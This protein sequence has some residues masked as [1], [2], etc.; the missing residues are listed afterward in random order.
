MGPNTPTISIENLKKSLVEVFP[1]PVVSDHFYI[2]SSNEIELVNILSIKGEL[3]H[4]FKIPVAQKS[5]T[6]ENPSIASGIYLLEIKTE[7]G[8]VY[9]KIIF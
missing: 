2:N 3:I 6:L 8:T 1:N 7:K 9:R 4:S 5:V